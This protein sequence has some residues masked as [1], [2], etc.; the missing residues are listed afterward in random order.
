MPFNKQIKLKTAV[1]LP[2]V[3]IF[4]VTF[5]V[6]AFVQKGNYEQMVQDISNKQLTY[7]T[8]NVEQRLYNFLE[9]P[10]LANLN[11]SHNIGFN[12]LYQKGNTKKI[13]DFF[14]SNFSVL[15][16]SI[17]QMDVV[18]FGGINAEYVGFRKELDHNYTL[19]VQDR[20]TQNQLVIYQNNTIS[21]DIRSVIENYDPRIRPWYAPVAES[22][23]PMWS[24]IYT[25]A[26]ERQEITLSSLSPVFQ[27]DQFVG[28]T[29]TDVKIDTFNAF[30]REMKHQTEAD[31]YIFD[32]EHRLIAHSSA[33]GVVS[34]G[35]SLSPKGARLLTTENASPVIKASAQRFKQLKPSENTTN[36][37]FVTYVNADRYFNK[38]TP[39]KDEFGVHWYIGVSISEP[40]LLGEVPYNQRNAWYIGLLI[41]IFGIGIGYIAFNRITAPITS[42]ASAAEHLAR[43]DWTSPMPKSGNIYETSLLVHA[44]N[45]MANNLKA[46]FKAL[47]TQLVYDS[48]TKLYSREGLVESCSNL[49]NLNGCL[50]LIG[51]DK[52][53]DINDSL[54]HQLADQLLIAIA[55]RLKSIFAS[56]AYIARIGGD[57]FALYLPL[58]QNEQEI[59]DEAQRILQLF[60]TPYSM[61]NEPIAVNVSVGIVHNFDSSNM[62]VWLR[63]GSIALS[64]A[65]LDS[66]RISY[67][68]PEMA[69]VSR[70]RTQM[71]TLLKVA[72]EKREFVPFYQPIVDL[73]SGEVLG[74]EAL[75]R[76]VSPE[77]GLVPPT[78][79]IPVAEESGLI[80]TI[81]EQILVQACIDT[82]KGIEEG[83]W[84]FDFRMHVNLSVS[85]LSSY[86]FL[87]QLE[88]ILRV[89]QLSPSNLALEITES[90]IVDNDPI[91]LN[92]M[93]A[94]KKLGIHIAIDDF[95]TGYSS[96]S[97]LHKL[98]FDCLKIDRAFV[99]QLNQDHLEESI[100]A[101]IINMMKG[102]KVHLIAEGIETQEQVELLHQLN[103]PQGQ[104][105]LFSKPIPY[106]EWPTNLVNM[107]QKTAN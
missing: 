92:N 104:G 6:I 79:F 12:R 84:A 71:V 76:W 33:G 74:A 56:D 19:M 95:G 5:G 54:G 1:L 38:V 22:Q 18:G 78:E 94:L 41:S 52:F 44:F 21:R 105:F 62:T 13:E 48:L 97:Y 59:Q 9:E 85:Q 14:H 70:K 99:L 8:N 81:G 27:D 31:V 17:S 77:L 51:I 93:V 90:K 46:S 87:P 67:Y 47:R 20:R 103:C 61:P 32:E 55:Q 49:K 86:L 50:F 66:T 16:Q 26:D 23:K 91:I 73:N 107:R 65:K 106:H 72:I 60:T 102:F 83:K 88:E 3:I 75:A 98:P 101:A 40:M 36:K 24:S 63:N 53:R 58:V 10:F 30:L 42:T 39:F 57:E 43:G 96:L 4:L 28:V 15:Y 89:T 45:E 82:V 7:L 25:N 29:V 64:N 11:L 80:N 2:F 100:V 34:W 37:N 69:G 68:A 35:T